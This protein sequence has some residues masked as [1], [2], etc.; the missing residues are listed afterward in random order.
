M[1]GFMG[2]ILRVDLS[3]SKIAEE[4][5]KEQ[6]CKMFLGG[7]GLATKYLWDEVPKGADPL[8]PDNALIFMTGPLTGT[9]SP[10]AGRYCV[11]TKSPLT[12]FWGEA[13]SGGN[14]GVHFKCTGFDGIIFKGASPKPVYLVI[15]EGKAELKDA[16]KL[17]GKSVIE[18]NNLIKQELGE[19][20]E[21]A[22]IGV[23]GENLVKYACIINDLHRAAGRCG[24]GAV[25]GSKKLKAIA[26]RGSKE[27]KVANKE[28][29]SEVSKTNYDLV[30]E[31]ML[32]ITL[33]TYGTA[34]ATD[35]INVRG[36]FPTRNWQ[37]GVFPD[38]EKIS[39]ITLTETL[40]TDRKHCYACPISCGRVSVVKS[41]PYAC[42]GEGPEFETIG[43]FGAM[44]ALESL[45]AVTYAHNLCDEYG[46]DVISAGSTIAFAMECY[47]KGIL[48]KAQTDGLELKFGDPDVVARLIPKIANREGIGDL[49]A[50]GTMRVA[51]KLGKGTEKFAMHVKGL[52]MPA[53]DPRAAKICGLAFAT[54]NRGGDHITAYVEGPAFIDIPF[55]CV[56]DS[57]IED[58]MVE[59]PKETK[60]VKDLEDAN[61]MFDAMGTCKFMG[62]ALA[63][64]DWADMIGNC[65]GW[66][67]TVNDFRKTGERIYNLAR[68]F[69]VREGCTRAD[70]SLP[71]RLYEDPL[72]EGAAEGHKVEKMD[73][74]LDAYYEFRGWDKKTAKP[75]PE[76]LK[77]LGLDFVIGK[78]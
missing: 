30:N 78:I 43:A 11:V 4:P 37:T 18:T 75:T 27:I 8:G 16:S 3:N 6:D 46:L 77:E 12:G 2:K 54:A 17:W 76:K 40:L 57:K 19:D 31:S 71:K 13:N 50:E 9:E 24:V 35:L 38:I 15:D 66:D 65:V 49:L 48:T 55:L 44:C 68:A 39:G 67:Y 14:W 74:M 7:S 41:G 53:Y 47:E 63:A 73:E 56:E 70:D 64:Q 72:P 25:M 33:E 22:C 10:S 61:T 36:G 69:S 1:F 29:F 59:N 21:V 42:K 26:V 58:A 60:V 34:M 45:E 51:K 23:G 28:K 32:K 62:M 20:F 5:L 52:E